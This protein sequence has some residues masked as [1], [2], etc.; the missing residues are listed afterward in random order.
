MDVIFMREN[1][2]NTSHGRCT[3][4][5]AYYRMNQSGEP[6]RSHFGEGWRLFCPFPAL[7]SVQERHQDRVTTFKLGWL[8]ETV[9]RNTAYHS[10][11]KCARAGEEGDARAGG[12]PAVVVFVP[13]VLSY[14][15]KV[16]RVTRWVR[17]N[18]GRVPIIS[19]R[20]NSKFFG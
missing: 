9:G 1:W 16:A 14:P 2:K 5:N 19:M 8:H 20:Q 13:P 4:L 17:A 7:A 11:T 12:L 10:S 18:R 6:L 15:R 3:N